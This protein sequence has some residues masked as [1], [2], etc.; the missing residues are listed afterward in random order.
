MEKSE[1]IK[2]I[3]TALAKFQ[4][5]IHNP[6]NTATNPFFKSKYAPLSEVLNTVRPILSKYGLSEIQDDYGNGDG[7]TVTTMLLHS[8]GEWLKTGELTAK[9]E[10]NTAQAMGSIITYLRRYQL[11]SL[12]GVSSEDDNDANEKEPNNKPENKKPAPKKETPKKLTEKER[13]AVI[14][15][16]EKYGESFCNRILNKYSVMFLAELTDEQLKKAYEEHEGA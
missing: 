15:R 6:A 3:A 11:S 2:E 7:V 16:L 14:A 1:S 12:L 13:A 5:E 8:S 9:P 10:K 4:A